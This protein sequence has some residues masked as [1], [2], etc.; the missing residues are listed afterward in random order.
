MSKIVKDLCFE[1]ITIIEESKS[2]ILKIS[3]EE[4]TK[5][6]PIEL[7]N[8]NS[9]KKKIEESLI[10]ISRKSPI[11]EIDLQ[12]L[13][14][15]I[16]LQLISDGLVLLEKPL[17]FKYDKI[18]IENILKEF[19]IQLNTVKFIQEVID[20]LNDRTIFNE[21]FDQKGPYKI[22]IS[23]L[24][25]PF[26]LYNLIIKLK[27]RMQLSKISSSLYPKIHDPNYFD[28]LFESVFFKDEQI[29][30]ISENLFEKIKN[31]DNL[32]LTMIEKLQSEK[33]KQF[34]KDIEGKTV[35]EIYQIILKRYKL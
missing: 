13:P 34:E 32:R 10:E 11:S 24:N 7:V 31:E 14:I 28:K 19:V 20:C 12:K 6:K 3:L 18:H 16:K 4:R 17:I 26:K 5:F 23:D 8:L 22:K 25:D 2:L 30:S 9:R 21:V 15:Q 33:R 35:W 29:K 27:I 1:L